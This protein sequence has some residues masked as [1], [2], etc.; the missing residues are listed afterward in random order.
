MCC[1]FW[2]V[3]AECSAETNSLCSAFK[4]DG[5]NLLKF[6][7]FPLLVLGI[8]H[9]IRHVKQF[10]VKLQKQFLFTDN[11]FP[12]ENIIFFRSSL[13]S[14]SFS[15]GY[16]IKME[17]KNEETPALDSIRGSKRV[18]FSDWEAATEKG[19]ERNIGDKTDWELHILNMGKGHC[20]NSKTLSTA[21]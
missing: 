19:W 21:I 12:L 11:T 2:N 5:A 14:G 16:V 17:N 9:Q 3:S 20:S 4:Q 1:R 13:S 18:L 8:S 6:W 7:H 10:P 15:F